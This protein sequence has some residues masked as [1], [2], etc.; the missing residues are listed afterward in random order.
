MNLEDH[1]PSA[2]KLG[3]YALGHLGDDERAELEA[4]LEG[5]PACRAELEDILPVAALLPKADPD[6]LEE[7]LTG[8]LVG[9]PLGLDQRVYQRIEQER[10][11][12]ARRPSGIGW[13]AAAIVLVGFALSTFFL[14]E[15]RG[16]QVSLRPVSD[17]TELSVE[18]QDLE[19]TATLGGERYSTQVEL[20]ARGLM[21]G[22]SY[23]V[24][25]EGEDGTRVPAGG[26]Q[27]YDGGPVTVYLSAAL[28]PGEAA[29]LVV[30]N[31]EGETG[32]RADLQGDDDGELIVP[33]L[34]GR[35]L[36]DAVEAAGPDFEVDTRGDGG[37]PGE[38]V[39]DQDP[40]PGD[41]ARKG[42]T[43]S[44]ALSSDRQAPEDPDRTDPG[45]SETE[46][47]EVESATYGS[48]SG[49]DAETATD[50]APVSSTLPANAASG[51]GSPM[52]S[53]VGAREIEAGEDSAGPSG[54]NPG[55]DGNA[56]EDT[57]SAD[58]PEPISA[59][60][61]TG[62]GPG[63]PSPGTISTPRAASGG[64][65]LP[66]PLPEG[67]PLPGDLFFPLPPLLPPA[68]DTLLEEVQQPVL[69]ILSEAPVVPEVPAA[70]EVPAV[71]D[72][73]QEPVRDAVPTSD[74]P[75]GD[76]D[77][78]KDVPGVG[79][80]GMNDRPGIDALPTRD[81]LNI[82]GGGGKGKR[83]RPGIDLPTKGLPGGGDRRGGGGPK[84]PKV[85]R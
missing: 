30:G 85:P 42:S 58:G 53:A 21:P 60:P 29:G 61:G 55:T 46:G 78:T 75:L 34:R 25:L 76:G 71:P 64:A 10:R 35:T 1:R 17:R 4:H 41:R 23:A 84:L 7:S 72:L 77:L 37:Q 80:G 24:W 56:G 9:P 52:L 66:E 32:L 14:T 18:L 5:C 70:P 12:K 43:V 3:A 63:L 8:P 67:A 62:S 82:D 31:P 33:D 44:V 68:P 28:P 38:T 39:V 16:E 83:D 73:L 22:Q 45:S 59:S 26:F 51:P 74:D 11:R 27:A 49:L 57:G 15:E 13:V 36:E 79:D 6:R 19:A 54:S 50:V 69:P 65:P 2:E 81:A 48:D 20:E 47:T 40:E